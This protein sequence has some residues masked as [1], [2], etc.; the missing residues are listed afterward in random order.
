MTTT[1]QPPRITDIGPP[2]YDKFLPPIVK[3]NYGLWKYH[4]NVAP[5]VLCH[6]AESGDKL[7]TV[8]AGFASHSGRSDNTQILRIGRQILRRVSALHQPQ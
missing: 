4:E 5:G 7:Y 1:P 8:R 3:K 2:A 6:V